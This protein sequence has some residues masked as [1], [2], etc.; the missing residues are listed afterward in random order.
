MKEDLLLARIDVARH[1]R[2]LD[3]AEKAGF[4]VFLIGVIYCNIG[5][6]EEEMLYSYEVEEIKLD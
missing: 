3:K 2:V 1:R 6:T 4:K 5:E